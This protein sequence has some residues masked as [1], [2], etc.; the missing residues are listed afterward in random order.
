MECAVPSDGGRSSGFAE[1]TENSNRRSVMSVK[2]RGGKRLRKR[3]AAAG[4]VCD[5]KTNM[6]EPLQ[7]HRNVERW[8]RN[9]GLWVSPGQRPA[10]TASPEPGGGLR[11]ALVASGV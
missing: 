5:E 1:Q 7:T 3:P 9:R 6:D 10:R 4:Q 8:R 11:A 2:S